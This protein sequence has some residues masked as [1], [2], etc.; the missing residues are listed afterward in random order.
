VR[1]RA[2]VLDRPVHDILD[3]LPGLAR[4]AARAEAEL[5]RWVGRLREK[6]T[7]WQQIADVVGIR[8]EDA[9]QRFDPSRPA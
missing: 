3:M 7:D 1:L 8:A 9:R 4:S 5:I 6:G 2:Q